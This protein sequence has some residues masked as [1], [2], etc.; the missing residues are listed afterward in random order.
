MAQGHHSHADTIGERRDPEAPLS[1]EASGKD[2]AVVYTL[3][4]EQEFALH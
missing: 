3:W 4:R 1:L 2:I